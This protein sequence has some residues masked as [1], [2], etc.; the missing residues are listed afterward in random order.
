MDKVQHLTCPLYDLVWNLTRP[1]Y[2]YCYLPILLDQSITEQ[3]GMHGRLC[4]CYRKAWTS[5]K[6]FRR[7][8]EGVCNFPSASRRDNKKTKQQQIKPSST[9]CVTKVSSPYTFDSHIQNFFGGIIPNL[10]VPAVVSKHSCTTITPYSRAH[11]TRGMFACLNSGGIW[12][13]LRNAGWTCERKH[14]F[15]WKNKCRVP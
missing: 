1:L 10:T 14:C 6:P 8:I 3:P 11:T 15:E 7:L 9:L 5:I 4:G 12:M 2:S 13:V